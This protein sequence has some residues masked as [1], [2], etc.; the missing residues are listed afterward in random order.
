MSR[1]GCLV[2]L[3]DMT[4][5][6]GGGSPRPTVQVENQMIVHLSHRKLQSARTFA[7]YNDTHA[8][9]G[10]SHGHASRVGINVAR[11]VKASHLQ[12]TPSVIGDA[13]AQVCAY[14]CW[15]CLLMMIGGYCAVSYITRA[16]LRCKREREREREPDRVRVQESEG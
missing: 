13:E 14:A 10:T 6:I 12:C 7:Y 1:E 3:G 16:D 9:I 11:R 5:R 2:D 4:E 8:E 15:T